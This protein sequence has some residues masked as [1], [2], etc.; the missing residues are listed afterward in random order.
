M[1]ST[2]T[3]IANTSTDFGEP[4]A[5]VLQRGA[6]V[7][8]CVHGDSSRNKEHNSTSLIQFNTTQFC[9]LVCVKFTIQ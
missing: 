9:S 6:Y 1:L 7:L 5:P 4:K 2:H 3:D 8:G